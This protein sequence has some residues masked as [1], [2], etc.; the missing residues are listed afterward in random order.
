M[1]MPVNCRYIFS[2]YMPANAVERSIVVW[3]ATLHEREKIM[4]EE[5]PVGAKYAFL[6]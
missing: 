6:M 1:G 5:I 3:S 2:Y 4:P